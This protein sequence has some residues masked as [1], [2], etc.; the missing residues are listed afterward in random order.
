MEFEQSKYEKA[1]GPMRAAQLSI[2]M[3]VEDTSNDLSE[4]KYAERIYEWLGTIECSVDE[5][6]EVSH[7]KSLFILKTLEKYKVNTLDSNII[8]NFNDVIESLKYQNNLTK[9]IEYSC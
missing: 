2:Q 6:F 1:V 7:D 8:L 9:N 5:L 3:Y 4:R